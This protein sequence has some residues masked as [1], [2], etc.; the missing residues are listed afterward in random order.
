MG[1]NACALEWLEPSAPGY[2]VRANLILR[3][4]D[5]EEIVVPRLQMRG[6]WGS[7]HPATGN[8]SDLRLFHFDEVVLAENTDADLAVRVRRFSLV[9]WFRPG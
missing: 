8:D 2:Q 9:S 1:L 6:T 5:Y 7:R 3:E 4:K